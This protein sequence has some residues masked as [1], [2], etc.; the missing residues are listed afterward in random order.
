M[1]AVSEITQLG[2]V[3]QSMQQVLA[4]TEFKEGYQYGEFDP[5]VDTLAAYGLAALV[6]G[7]VAVKVGLLAK[8]GALLLAFK[9][10]II[11]GLAVIGGLLSR[12]FKK[13][14]AA[15]ESDVPA[16]TNDEEL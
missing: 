9:K 6:G 4:I 15:A 13:K 1:N 7:K 3:E 14:K 10:F 8:L 5:G 11:I 16:V 12:L 2:L